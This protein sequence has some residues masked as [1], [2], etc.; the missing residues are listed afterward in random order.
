MADP[1]LLITG[2]GGLI[3]QILWRGLADSFGV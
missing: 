1:K 2:H 3:G